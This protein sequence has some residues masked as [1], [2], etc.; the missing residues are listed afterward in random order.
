MLCF[1]NL[2]QTPTADTLAVLF[3]NLWP[4][5]SRG[6]SKAVY[7]VDRVSRPDAAHLKHVTYISANA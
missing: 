7:I 4:T 5:M 1:A 3:F 2:F 6:S